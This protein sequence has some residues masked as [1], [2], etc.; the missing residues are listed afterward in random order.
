MRVL[1]CFVV[2]LTGAAL[3]SP[4]VAQTPDVENLKKLVDEQRN[5]I[6][7][8]AERLE[9]LGREMAALRAEMDET[10]EIARAA[11]NRLASVAPGPPAADQQSLET[12]LEAIE[13]TIQ[14]L[15]EL[16]AKAVAAGEFPGSIE[17]PGTGAAIKIGGQ[18]R[19]NLV[20]TLGPLGTD[21]RFIASSI[22]VGDE[23]AGESARTTY[24]AEA[25][26]L[27][28]DLRAP[29][30]IG[31]VRT[32]IEG[33]FA[34]TGE[35][36]RLRHAYIQTNRWMFGQTW[37]TFSDPEVEPSDIDFE[38]ENALSRF[39]QAQ[40]RYTRTIQPRLDLSLA[41]ENPAPDLTGAEGVNLTPDFIG[42][43]K[44]EPEN[45]PVNVLTQPA[46]LQ[47]AVLFRTLRGELVSQQDV[48]L[49][50]AGFGGTLSGVLIPRWNA[51]DRL[52]FAAYGGWGIGRY[53]TDLGAA[54]GQDAVYDPSV[55]DL[56]ALPVSALYMG[57]EHRWRPAFLSTFTYGIVNVHNLDAQ[58]DDALHRTQR[59][60]ANLTWNPFRRAD[61]VLEFLA[62]ER[63][64]KNGE[65]GFSTQIQGGWRLRF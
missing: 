31:A 2:L 28:L 9:E 58:T 51:A 39:R 55:N 44:W 62:G 50:T 41:I 18:A 11:S 46:H 47:A 65:D 34:G 23:R 27:N 35:T 30:R 40:L 52:K 15:P 14:R 38:G 21:D 8:Q 7:R 12:R 16:P 25:S 45:A 43:L 17:I 4:A 5:L 13:R 42:R 53:I 10:K 56:R 32:Y 3:S 24:T 57:Y 48:T 26:R 49:S 29:T 6:A 20:H 1:V 59:A 60:T 36:A 37:S 33:D 63:V 54:G 19:F 61:I 64:N 22:P